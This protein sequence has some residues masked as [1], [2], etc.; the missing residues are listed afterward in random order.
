MLTLG[1]VFRSRGYP[2]HRGYPGPVPVPTLDRDIVAVGDTVGD[3]VAE[4]PDIVAEVYC[5]R[6]T[7]PPGKVATVG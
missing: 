7:G 1:W 4:D 3:I 2:Y 5:N 6:D